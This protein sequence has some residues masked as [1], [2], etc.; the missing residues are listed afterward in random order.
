A[1][2]QWIDPT[3]AQAPLVKGL[4]WLLGRMTN[5]A[6][7][8]A[9]YNCDDCR[10]SFNGSETPTMLSMI[11]FSKGWEQT[12]DPNYQTA[13]VKLTNWALQYNY[14]GTAQSDVAYAARVAIGLASVIPDL[15]DPNLQA[16]AKKRLQDIALFLRGQENPDG[17][18]GAQS[19]PDHPIL[20]TSQSL[21]VLAL[22]GTKG[23]DPGLRNAIVW[24]I[25]H[26]MANGAWSEWNSESTTPIHWW[27]ETTWAMIAL[28]A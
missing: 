17:S 6:N 9:H 26:Q 27:D 28:P 2:S 23:T 25:N 16:L 21:Y 19:A 3:T 20:R 13:M 12:K 1:L 4:N 11:A 8:A 24:L 14:Q 7:G 5:D 22:A 15:Q 18:F 10:I